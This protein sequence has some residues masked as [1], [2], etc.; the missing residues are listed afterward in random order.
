VTES[1][2]TGGPADTV[3]VE[4][5]N[6][7]SPDPSNYLFHATFDEGRTVHQEMSRDGGGELLIG[8][9]SNGPVNG[10]YAEP[11]TNVARSGSHSAL[12]SQDGAGGTHRAIRL[13]RWA[14]LGSRREVYFSA[15]FYFPR[16]YHLQT[17]GPWGWHQFW[18]FPTANST[19]NYPLYILGWRNVSPDAMALDL[20]WWP[21]SS[22]GTPG[23]YEGQNGRQVFRSP[24]TIP[25]GEWFQ[26]EVRYVCDS[27]FNGSVQFWLNGQEVFNL[28]NVRT[29]D[30]NRGSCY[31]GVTN[32]G[33]YVQESRID[34]YVDDFIASPTRVGR[35]EP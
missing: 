28:T 1:G 27:G 14:E 9:S 19:R 22:F 25:V 16:V 32:Y 21:T 10:S 4:V 7:S 26:M 34:F 18:Q 12:L 33:D 29:A 2:V 24:V 11:S 13:Q 3:Q 35:G 20:T 17:G 15:W 30:P 23:P 5:T 31:T 6:T 8:Y